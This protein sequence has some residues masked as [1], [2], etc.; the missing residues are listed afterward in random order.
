[1]D[2]IF[3]IIFAPVNSNVQTEMK[4]NILTSSLLPVVLLGGMTLFSAQAQSKLDLQSKA[5]LY[6][7]R[8]AQTEGEQTLTRANAQGQP[9]ID[10]FIRIADEDVI[11]QLEALGV[12]VVVNLK[13]I[14]TCS[15]PLDCLDQLS[16]LDGVQGISFAKPLKPHNDVA[17]NVTHV[18][19]VH[20][21]ADRDGLAYTGKDVIYGT[22]DQGFD[23]NHTAFKNPDGSSR[24]L[25]AYLP[26]CEDPS[27]GGEKYGNYPGYVFPSEAIGNLS[28]DYPYSSHGTH[29]MGIGAGGSYGSDTYYGMAPEADI[30]TVAPYNN[31]EVSVLNGVSFM[32]DKAKDLGKPISINISLGSNAGPHDGTSDFDQGLDALSGPG[33]IISISVGNEG[34]MKNRL[35]KPAGSRVAS[36]IYDADIAWFDALGR[37]EIEG[38][39]RDDQHSFSMQLAVVD[40]NTGEILTTSP[41]LEVDGRKDEVLTEYQ[42][43]TYFNEGL[44]LLGAD[45]SEVTGRRVG[46]ITAATNIWIKDPYAL[47]LIVEGDAEVD[48]F[49]NKFSDFVDGGF[50]E[51]FDNGDSDASFNNIGTASKVISVG[52]YITR[53]TWTST[54]GMVVEKTGTLGDYA[55]TSSYGTNYEGRTF[56][57]IS[58]PGQYLISALNSAFNVTKDY[59]VVDEGPERQYWA[60]AGTSMAC[61]VV[62]GTIA[63]W[64]QA[65]PTLD[66][67]RVRDIMEHTAIHDEYTEATPIRFGYG[68]I[69][70]KA[71]LDYIL[72]NMPDAISSLTA[73]EAERGIL[74]DAQNRRIIIRRNGQEYDVMGKSVTTGKR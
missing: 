58:A 38:W 34:E 3:F 57:T 67:D 14:I 47:A 15:I 51:L 16:A 31:N 6:Q 32:V 24:I 71:G 2:I 73:D 63:L 40:L 41:K 11:P 26:L 52:S 17:R 29:T 12:K 49:G 25:Y 1:M 69:D 10:A 44:F 5:T 70:A 7:L 74:F 54:E 56:P 66:A 27:Q 28:T 18:D 43:D 21:M 46:R 45:Y 33:V 42:D 23:Y 62:A 9:C 72:H 4:A 39:S 55:P 13:S 8:S 68:K 36:L 35:Y 48:V 20:V 60:A 65:D 37:I 64:L 50:P 61:P 59:L 30:I 53:V 19:E 22:I